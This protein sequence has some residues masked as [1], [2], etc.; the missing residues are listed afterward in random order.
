ML[1]AT[2]FF[3]AFFGL[4]LLLLLLLW[5]WP[6]PAGAALVSL[7]KVSILI[8]EASSPIRISSLSAG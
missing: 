2:V 7:P 3:S 5:R 8:V 4:Y 6:R 1:F